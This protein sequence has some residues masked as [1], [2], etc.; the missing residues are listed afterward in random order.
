M[1]DVS[2][3]ITNYN[4]GR[5]IGRTIRSC[6]K[7]SLPRDRYEIIVVDDC[8][9]DN[10]RMIIDSFED[11]I[12]RVYLPEN[13]GVAGASNAGIKRALGSLIIRV[14]ADDYISENTLLFLSE[15]LLQNK[16]IGFVYADHIRV[17]DQENFLERVNLDNLQNILDHGAGIMFRKSHLE[18]V[19]LYDPTMRHADDYDLLKRYYKNFDGYY[20]RLP[21][22]R[23]RQHS[24][25]QTKLGKRDEFIKLSNAKNNN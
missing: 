9:T 12:V 8:S 11:E 10:S 5:F 7:Q 13:L 17:D 6:L 2:I 19:G 16:N 4:R 3:I 18:T 15:I 22:Y 14:D 20:L 25:N 21:L 23:Y 24:G 1:L